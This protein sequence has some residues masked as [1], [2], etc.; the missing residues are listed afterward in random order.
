MENETQNSYDAE[1]IKV[2][3]GLEAVRK[4]PG[5]Y[6]GDPND[7]TG[8][9]QL[10]YEA[11]DNAID[12][13]LAG[14][15]D[16]VSVTLHLDGG[17]SVEDNGRGIPVGM[18]A[19]EGRSAAE[20]IM[21]VLHAGGKF[22]DNSYKVSGGL[23][24]VGISCVNALS[25]VLDLTICRDGWRHVQKYEFGDPAT[26]LT[27]MEATDHTGT[28]IRFLPDLEIF[29]EHNQFSFDILSQRLRELSFLN[30]GVKIVIRDEREEDKE[31]T[32]QYEGGISS[33]VLHLAKNKSPLHADPVYFNETREDVEVE[34]ALQWTDAYQEQIHCFTNNIRNRDGGTHLSGFRDALT[35]TLNSYAGAEGFTKGLKGSLS[36]DDVREGLIAVI[37][38]KVPD[39]KFSSQTKEKLVSSEVKPVVQGASADRLSDWLMENPAHARNLITK[40]IG[41]ARA[42]DAARKARELVR[43]KGVLD[44]AA[45][46]GKLADCQEKAPERSELYL[47]EGDSAGGSAKQGRDRATQAILPLRGKILNVEKARLDKMLSSQE[48]TTLITALGTGIGTDNFDI[49]KLRYHKIII[50][51]DAD[52][53]GSH[54]RTLLLTFFYRQMVEIIDKG[55]LYI[56]QPPLFRAR[57]GKQVRYLKNEAAM[58]DFLVEGASKS[59]KVKLGNDE[60]IE[61]EHLRNFLTALNSFLEKLSM[62]QRRGDPRVFE[63]I[64]LNA[65]MGESLDFES[66]DALEAVAT[67]VK[68]YLD[69]NYPDEIPVRFTIEKE[70]SKYI[71]IPDEVNED[72]EVVIFEP[73]VEVSP[74]YRIVMRTRMTGGERR[75]FVDSQSR[76]KAPYD[77]ALRILDKLPALKADSFSLL[78]GDDVTEAGSIREL[79]D[80]LLA[81]GRKGMDFQRYKGLGEMNPEQLWETTMDPSVRTL[82]QVRIDDTVNADDVFTVLMGDSV[83]PRRLFIEENALSVKNLDV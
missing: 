61:G 10:V 59:A 45:L 53:D 30:K 8:L 4:R 26:P 49:A 16:Q 57:K 41:A 18:H 44:S 27:Q 46:P 63:A 35:R 58:Q 12:E 81:I 33:F 19:E 23:H 29:T 34:M 48:I 43:R 70:P 65:L 67:T 40:A 71:P 75:T 24:G 9:H 55:Y 50:M 76:L 72:G 36:G 77:S 78:Q 83:E 15:C 17:C 56:A 74:Y 73:R 7:G 54:I 80:M 82:L 39:P 21:T 20:V 5:M 6:I 42:R 47:V 25:A 37:S 66:S 11:V 64:L 60:V 52:V 32:F 68:S 79:L 51:T 28:H 3:K 31:H 22:D 1:S 69:T 62:V 2:L 38:C 14:H 13:A